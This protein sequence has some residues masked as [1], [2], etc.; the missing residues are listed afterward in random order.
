MMGLTIVDGHNWLFRAF[1]GVPETARTRGGIQVNAVYGFFAFLRQIVAKHPN[2]AL[3]V[4]FDSETGISDKLQIQNEYKAGRTVDTNMFRQL[5]I[6]K[7]ILDLMGICWVEHSAYEADDIIAS[8]ATQWSQKD[9]VIVSSND[10]DFVQLV[11]AQIKLVRSVNGRLIDCDENYIKTKFN[12]R[13]DQYIEYLSM[14]GDKTDNIA[15]IPGIGKKTASDL[16]NKYS[17]TE[18]IL[19]HLT[20]LPLGLQN[21]IRIGGDILARNLQFIKMKTDIDIGDILPR[22]MSAPSQNTVQQKIGLCLGQLGIG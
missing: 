15:G 6:I 18:N 3:V 9:T 2:N 20:E 14:T 21:K 22:D 12:I 5:P 17:T 13:P 4:I 19:A 11:N 7:N 8:I 10:F 16:L 1:Y